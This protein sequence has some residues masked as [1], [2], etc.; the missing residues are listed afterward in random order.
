MTVTRDVPFAVIYFRFTREIYEEEEDVGMASV[1]V[2]LSDAQAPIED[3]VWLGITSE[4]QSAISM[5][6]NTYSALPVECASTANIR[7]V[8]AAQL[9]VFPATF[10]LQVDGILLL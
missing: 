4:D 5:E 10:V 6:R 8:M 9:A 2:E 1:C 7:L 3:E